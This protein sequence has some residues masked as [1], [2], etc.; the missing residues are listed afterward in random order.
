MA[1]GDQHEIGELPLDLLDEHS[2]A[3]VQRLHVEHHDADLA[4]DQK[5]ADLVGRRHVP[6]APGAA[7]R[8]AQGLQE[9]IVRSQN[10]ELDDVAREAEFQRI[11]RAAVLVRS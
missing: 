5:V 4:R 11:Q 9:N 3:V 7:H 10:D 6:Q 8:L 2:R 1:R